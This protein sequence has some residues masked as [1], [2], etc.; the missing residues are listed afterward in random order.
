MNY[1]K[2]KTTNNIVKGKLPEGILCEGG[3]CHQCK[4]M[5]DVEGLY[6]GGSY[7]CSEKDIQKAA[8]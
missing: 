7:R 5:I 3:F 1:Q 4:Y 6:Y 8:C 2:N